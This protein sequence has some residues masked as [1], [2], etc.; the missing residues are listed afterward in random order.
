VAFTGS[1]GLTACA[2]LGAPSFILFGAYFPGWMFCALFGILA[3]VSARIA[4][5]ASGLSEVLPLQLFVAV[6]AGLIVAVVLWL[7]WFGQ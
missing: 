1:L 2:A 7:S 4:M 5:V 6:S 3:A